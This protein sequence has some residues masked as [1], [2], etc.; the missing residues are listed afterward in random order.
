MVKGKQYF[1]NPY[2]RKICGF[3]TQSALVSKSLKRLQYMIQFTQNG[4]FKN[5]WQIIFYQMTSGCQGNKMDFFFPKTFPL[6]LLVRF[7]KYFT[8]MFLGWPFS[9]AVRETLIRKKYDSGVVGGGGGGGFL[10]YTDMKNFLTIL[11]LWNS[12]SDF[13]ILIMALV[14]WASCPIQTL[15]IS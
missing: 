1:C 14:N 4:G 5:L 8:E 3:S 13:E 9:R 6:K 7:L 12:W 10:Y 11:F 15:R 2:I